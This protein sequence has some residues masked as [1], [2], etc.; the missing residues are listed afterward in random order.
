MK[1][2]EITAL[3]KEFCEAEEL[4]QHYYKEDSEDE[5]IDLPEALSS[6][7]SYAIEKGKMFAEHDL[8]EKYKIGW[9]DG[10]SEG[11]SEGKTVVSSPFNIGSQNA[12][13]DIIQ[14]PVSQPKNINVTQPSEQPKTDKLT[15]Q[16]CKDFIAEMVV[17]HFKNCP[18]EHQPDY[19]KGFG[20]TWDLMVKIL[21]SYSE[22]FKQP[23]PEFTTDEE[24][25]DRALKYKTLLNC[26]DEEYVA[27]ITAA[28]W[29]RDKMK[30]GK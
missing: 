1:E 3:A 13:R 23:K 28:T 17:E 14:V 5:L 2:N 15:L 30:G 27:Y 10:Y 19:A 4:D 22:Q 29:M 8:E 18:S 25:K 12:G 26:S 24:I 6:F 9:K 11:Y 21:T 20:Q 16:E 7:L